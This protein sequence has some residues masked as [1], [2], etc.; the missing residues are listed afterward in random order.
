VVEEKD[1]KEAPKRTNI[2][3]MILML[4]F[5]KLGYDWSTPKL[6]I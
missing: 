2:K 1:D 3:G 6:V 4:K 5:K